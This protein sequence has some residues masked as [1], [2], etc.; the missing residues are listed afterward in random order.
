[1]T[2]QTPLSTIAS[3]LRTAATR[4]TGPRYSKLMGLADQLDAGDTTGA[5]DQL[6]V[7]ATWDH[8]LSAPLLA[9]ADLLPVE[10]AK[11]EKEPV[12]KDLDSAE[13]PEKARTAKA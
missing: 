4:V 5:R 1:M 6:L 3:Q 12:D 13:K 11:K 9:L 2:E 7:A 10:D 8:Y